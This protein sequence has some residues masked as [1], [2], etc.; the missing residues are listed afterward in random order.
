V[1]I[2]L[3][4]HIVF[5]LSEHLGDDHGRGDTP[6]ILG[7]QTQFQFLASKS[8]TLDE[9]SKHLSSAHP[10]YRDNR[11]ALERTAL[12]TLLYE[13]F[14]NSPDYRSCPLGQACNDETAKRRPVDWRRRN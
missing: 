7:Y 6:T 10:F 8:V 9:V 4:I 3:N 11:H 13:E 12:T 14:Q 2:A 1:F 5:I